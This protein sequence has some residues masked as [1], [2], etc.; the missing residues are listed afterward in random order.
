MSAFKYAILISK[1]MKDL[2]SEMPVEMIENMEEV[3]TVGEDV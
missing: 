3:D 1:V 2:D